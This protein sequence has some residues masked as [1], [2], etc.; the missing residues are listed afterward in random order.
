[1]ASHSKKTAHVSEQERWDVKARRL[2][3]F[4]GQLLL[5]PAR[6]IFIDETGATTNM[7]RRCGRC[8]RGKRLRAAIPHGHYKT[9]TF[10]SGLRLSGLVAPKAL[11][12][13]MNAE[14]FCASKPGCGTISGRR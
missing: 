13:A 9:L 4:E 1:M 12:G 3:W 2:A 11:D 7:A 5:D 6:L 8:K 14:R 10:V